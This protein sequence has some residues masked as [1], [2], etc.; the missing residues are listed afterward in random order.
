[1]GQYARKRVYKFLA[2]VPWFGPTVRV[3]E[4]TAGDD[5]FHVHQAHGQPDVRARWDVD[6]A[7]DDDTY[8]VWD[9]VHLFPTEREIGVDHILCAIESDP[10]IP[11][12][13]PPAR[14]EEHTS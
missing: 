1:M 11:V 7:V 12:R 6:N 14:S 5:F 13:E 10:R 4:V 3:L 2:T 8:R 9:Y